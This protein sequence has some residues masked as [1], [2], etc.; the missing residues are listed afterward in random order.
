MLSL[1]GVRAVLFTGVRS[2]MLVHASASTHQ[3]GYVSAAPGQWSS[4]LTYQ[5]RRDGFA[6]AAPASNSS[7]AG[8]ANAAHATA[9]AAAAAAVGVAELVTKP[10]AWKGGELAANVDCGL[11]GFIAVSV[12]DGSTGVEVP[13]YTAGEAHPYDGNST[14]A[15]LG[16]TSG[17]TM[18]QLA[19]RSVA[20][21]VSMTGNVKLYS[22]RGAFL[23]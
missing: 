16:W 5:L 8:G 13:G 6:Y 14:N 15:T 11:A 19:G 22:F 18:Q 7:R 2:T 9:V 3:H 20:L 17:A 21:K 23:F 12:L 1:D 10:L 4:L